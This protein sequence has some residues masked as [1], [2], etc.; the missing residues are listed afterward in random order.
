MKRS[1]QIWFLVIY[2]FFTGT[3]A[4]VA[5]PEAYFVHYGAESGLPQHTITDILQDRK[6]FMW[7]GT[8]D[9]L[10]KFDGYTFTTYHLPAG[11]AIESGSS[12]ID[13]LYEDSYNN[14][15]AL[16]HDSQAFRFNVESES[17][18]GTNAIET[19]R[20]NSFVTSMIQPIESGTV[21]LLS[22]KQGCIAITDSLFNAD[23]YHTE[24]MNLTDNRVH[25]IHEDRKENTWILTARGLTL[26]PSDG[27][28]PLFY[29]H[30]ASNSRH[31][32]EMPFYSVIEFRDE[33]WFGSRDGIVWRF[34][35]DK[36]LFESL[37]TGIRSDI[38]AIHEISSEK[39]LLVSRYAG[40]AI[41]NVHDESVDLYSPAEVPAM[42]FNEIVTAYIDR[43]NNVWLETNLLGVSKFNPYTEKYIHYAPY[44]ES[45]VS[46]VFPPNFFIFE[47]RENRL[48]V[49]PRGGGFSIYNRAN[50]ALLPFYNEPFSPG[51]MFSNMMHAAYSDRQGNLWM[52]T[53]SHGLEKV[54][55]YDESKF[56]SIQLNS[57]INSTISN[58]VR[59]IFEDSLGNIWAAT[60][61]GRIHVIDSHLEKKGI[62][63]RSGEIGRGVPLEGIAY[64]ITEDSDRNIWIGTKGEGV[65]KLIR[66]NEG[67]TF[68]IQHY[69]H[70]PDDR[71][72]L[73]DDQVYSI[74][75][76]K[77]KN[78]WVGTFG[79]GINLIPGGEVEAKIINHRNELVNYPFEQGHRVR[80]ISSDRFGNILVGTT[81][82][83]I[84]LDRKSV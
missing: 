41:F 35:K 58:D 78:I 19:Y 77:N 25:A 11:N 61:D 79:G 47:D 7:F 84:V 37:P 74:Y 43:S 36:N 44:I 1:Q 69:K 60:K 26:L 40:F 5:Q 4:L 34:D 3:V 14:I 46:S 21:W 33:L 29:F 8:W 81:L 55:F 17:F 75:E 16:S 72:S 18:I 66:K 52:C 83:C 53:R 49:H 6:G 62:V 80:V 27:S 65:Y 20:E 57:N 9:G 31:K 73:S 39:T 82:G 30:P 23:V 68:N 45:T 54:I 28:A 38:I 13:H 12:R 63:T 64:C 32:E 56:R 2:L 51:W 10:S 70:D 15:W 24:N 22:Q 59:P 48:W 50:D 76:D 42:S 67:N 71:Y